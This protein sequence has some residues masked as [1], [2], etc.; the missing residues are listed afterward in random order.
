[1]LGRVHFG[2]RSR[3]RRLRRL[4]S[5]VALSLLALQV[6]AV[7]RVFCT[8]QSVERWYR[9]HWLCPPRIWPFLDYPMYKEAHRVGTRL[10]RPLVLARTRDGGELRLYPE[11]AEMRADAHAAME[12]LRAGDLERTQ[13]ALARRMAPSEFAGAELRIETIVLERD[14]F[15]SEAESVLI[16]LAPPPGPTR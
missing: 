2:S 6:V 11:R 5:G 1:M 4:A 15:R 3:R 16:H 10:E 13:N 7:S 14:G 8:P 9:N 12:G